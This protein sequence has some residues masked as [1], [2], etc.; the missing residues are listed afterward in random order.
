MLKLFAVCVCLFGVWQLGEAQT[1]CTVTVTN[2]ENPM[3]LGDGTYNYTTVYFQVTKDNKDKGKGK[4]L[5]AY[6]INNNPAAWTFAKSK[7][8]FTAGGKT[9]GFKKN[10]KF[11]PGNKNALYKVYS[12]ALD[13]KTCSSGG[14]VSFDISLDKVQMKATKMWKKV[15]GLKGKAGKVKLS[16]AVTV[17][18]D[19]PCDCKEEPVYK[20]QL[21]VINS[22]ITY[23]NISE[24]I[25]EGLRMYGYLNDSSDCALNDSFHLIEG[26]N[27]TLGSVLFMLTKDNKGKGKG[28]YLTTVM[29][30][31]NPIMYEL[32]SKTKVGGGGKTKGN[33]KH[34]KYLVKNPFFSINE[35]ALMKKKK[36][37]TCVGAS[38]DVDF[39][40]EFKKFQF[41]PAKGYKKL[42]GDKTKLDKAP[43]TITLTIPCKTCTSP[44]DFKTMVEFLGYSMAEMHLA[45]TI[46]DAIGYNEGNRYLTPAP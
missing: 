20:D 39:T 37:P 35:F 2:G 11:N 7:A 41:K 13:K 42:S 25:Y 36:A 23:L 16:S 6:F 12:W 18:I 21:K 40:V 19:V 28:M 22:A 5:T 15:M 14:N 38:G 29:I 30:V 8:K 27:E 31:S 24:K 17:S 26:T 43:S 34:K 3:A 44:P 4:Y 10:D 33:K 46:I 1:D 32:K 45:D 9:K